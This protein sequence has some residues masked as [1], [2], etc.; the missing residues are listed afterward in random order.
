MTKQKH[1]FYLHCI[2]RVRN[3]YTEWCYKNK[4]KPKLP[5][6]KADKIMVTSIWFIIIVKFAQ[7]FY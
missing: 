5:Q 4:M 7:V 2:V 6:V 1:N 3:R